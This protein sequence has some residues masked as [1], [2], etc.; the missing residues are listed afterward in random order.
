MLAKLIASYLIGSIVGSLLLGKL[1]GVDIRN[2][3][4]GNAGAT[5]ALRTQGKAFA[6]GTA[7]I[8]FGKGVF[9]A[10][11]I[12]PIGWSAGGALSL[13]ETQLACGLAASIGHCYPLFHGFRGGKGAGTLFGMLAWLFP[14]VALAVLALW[15]LVLT[16]TGY[17]GLGT[18]IAGIAFPIALYLMQGWPGPILMGLAIAAALLLT[19][20]H[21]S[22]LARLRAGT[23]HRFER[24][25]V[26]AR[27]WGRRSD[28]R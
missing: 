27:I 2:Q 13:I 1:R 5:N 14:M 19:F 15:L 22:N 4:S 21:R 18:V 25:R 17:V 24:A 6:I 3:G 7:L 20:T 26:W 11:V 10:A 9:A 8:D 12:A 16:T 28:K 23:E